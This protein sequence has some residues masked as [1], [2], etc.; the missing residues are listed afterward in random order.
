MKLPI[1]FAFAPE[2]KVRNLSFALLSSTLIVVATGIT[3]G[4]AR[5]ELP[6]P[7]GVRQAAVQVFFYD[8][9]SGEY[10]S[11]NPGQLLSLT[12]QK[13][14]GYEAEIYRPK[15]NFVGAILQ[16]LL[17]WLSLWIALG[18]S[19]WL[20]KR[21]LTTSQ[22]WHL[23][24]MAGSVMIWR[25]LQAL[26]VSCWLWLP[27]WRSDLVLA[28]LDIVQGYPV[29]AN[30]VWPVLWRGSLWLLTGTATFVH[31]FI[32]LRRSFSLSCRGSLASLAITYFA[33][34][35]IYTLATAQFWR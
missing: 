10:I 27:N 13:R 21:S 8:G 23:G 19:V 3:A 29:S 28:L 30:L 6:S 16:S 35:L 12:L 26:T 11:P 25:L 33:A 15:P 34:R 7:F 1:K 31:I 4:A 2:E 32:A 9:L 20:F 22:W 24:S 17:A 14:L 5:V 18:L